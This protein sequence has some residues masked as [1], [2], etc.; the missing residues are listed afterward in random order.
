[1]GYTKK[2]FECKGSSLEIVLTDTGLMILNPTQED[3][4]LI[5]T[6]HMGGF[7]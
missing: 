1:M 3:S 7:L 4:K 6:S 5:R 2:A